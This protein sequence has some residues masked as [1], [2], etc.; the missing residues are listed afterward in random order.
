MQNSAG[1]TL[2][3]LLMASL[4]PS[5]VIDAFT[6][7]SPGVPICE[8]GEVSISPVG[9]GLINNT[10]K[11]SCQFQTNFLLQKINTQVFPNPEQVQENCVL[12]CQYAEFEM[13]GLRLPYIR[14]YGENK[15]LYRDAA[16]NYWRAF[17]FID[18]SISYPTATTAEQAKATAIAFA[19]YSAA[20]DNMNIEN[21]H[22]TIP[23][24]HNLNLRYQQFE[25]SLH[26]ENYERQSKAQPIIEEIKKRE[27]Y[28]FF[29]DEI[30]QSAEF[31]K[32]VVHHDAKISNVLFNKKTG[33]LICPVDLDTTMPG[34]FFSD[35]GD[36]IR[37]MAC[38]VDENS[39]DFANLSIRK[40]YYH[41]ITDGYLS[42]MNKY[43]TS[44][45][46]KYFHYSGLLIIYMQALRF[47][48]DY[49]N[50]DIYYKTKYPEHNY[51]RVMNQLTLLKNLE[52]FL[53]NEYH[54]KS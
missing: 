23:G 22:E 42:V 13:T 18:D 27:K 52:E 6:G 16:G 29:F 40:D 7:Y 21:L 33:K 17:E 32:R 3:S 20:F 43:L 31:P 36:M 28:K 4:V 24:F 11:V 8:P 34:Y 38:S 14:E 10:F 9:D 19:K 51:D 53:K 2:I 39:K 5:E 41:A 37:S 44:S 47:L 26:S 35:P 46:K 49:L 1:F 45:E 50:G 12:L 48:T 30:T 25:E 15:S 54:F